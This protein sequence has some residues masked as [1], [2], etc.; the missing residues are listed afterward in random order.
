MLIQKTSLALALALVA[1]V[2][3]QAA[4][5]VASTG[6]TYTQSFDS[7]ANSGSAAVAWAN[8]STLAGW[9]LFNK[10]SVAIATYTADNGG[11]NAGSFRS[12]GAAGVAERALGGSASGGTYFGSPASNTV[13]GWIAVALN[14][15]TGAALSGFKLA[16]DGEQWR[17]GGNTAAQTMVLEYGFGASFATVASWTAPG[18]NFDFTSPVVGATAAAVDGNGAGLVAGRGGEVSTTWAAGDTLWVRW[19]EKNDAGNDHGL[20]IDNV[21]IQAVSAVPEPSTYAMLLAGLGCV[22]FIARRRKAA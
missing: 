20:A 19:V 21:S 10:D 17:N 8:D 11:S 5:S 6:G 14:N 3:A 13:A 7:L 4:I 12:Y 16:F 1:A 9:S 2:P 18:G 22:G 15:D